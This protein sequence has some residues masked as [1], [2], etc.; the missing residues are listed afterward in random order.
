MTSTLV[1]F[2]GLGGRTMNGLRLV[3]GRARGKCPTKI[4]KN[5]GKY[6]LADE[7]LR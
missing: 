5:C 3:G 1:L 4:F 6:M 2:L 7:K